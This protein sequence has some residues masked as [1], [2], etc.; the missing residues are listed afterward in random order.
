ME[1]N[2]NFPKN[3]LTSDSNEKVDY[4][5]KFFIKHDKFDMVSNEIINWRNITS[6]RNLIV[7]VGPPASGKTTSIKRL[8]ESD[9]ENNGN[10][11]SIFLEVP[12]FYDRI[13]D[14]EAF[15]QLIAK[16]IHDPFYDKKGYTLGKKSKKDKIEL[17]RNSIADQV[18]L[19]GMNTFYLDE[20]HRFNRISKSDFY[21]NQME[22]IQYFTSISEVLFIMAGTY[23]L[24]NLLEFQPQLARRTLVIPFSR[25]NFDIEFFSILGIFEKQ[26]PL[27]KTPDLIS[28]ADY[29]Y[30][31]SLGCLGLL[32]DWLLDALKLSINPNSSNDFFKN[33]HVTQPN[34]KTLIEIIND[35]EKGEQDINKFLSKDLKVIKERM[36][37][38]EPNIGVQEILTSSPNDISPTDASHMGSSS[39]LKKHSKKHRVGV[40]KPRRIPVGNIE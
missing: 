19:R 21:K 32:K 26:L 11:S 22:N 5:E 34:E 2:S 4:F 28:N 31:G 18:K 3:L 12:A 37:L 24:L 8:H 13:F 10:F 29:L 17:L 33:L 27:Y 20:A 25:F 16:K 23:E 39:S 35:I 15:Y 9:I 38:I 7:I 6:G 36:K 40:M 14:W 30:H 1:E